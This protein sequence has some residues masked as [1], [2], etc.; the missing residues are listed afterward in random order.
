MIS[1]FF[2]DHVSA[3][4]EFSKVLN[5]LGESAIVRDDEPDDIGAAFQKFSVVTRDLSE[6]LKTLV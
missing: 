1:F 2:P 5:R 6:Q 3:E 4:N